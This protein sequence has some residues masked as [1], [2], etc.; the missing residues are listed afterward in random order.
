MVPPRYLEPSCSIFLSAGPGAGKTALLRRWHAASPA[1]A[2]YTGLTSDDLSV[3]FFL[4]RLLLPWP[5][6]RAPFEQLRQDLPDTE[7]GALL[8]LALTAAA[9]DFRLLLDDFHLCE[10]TPLEPL[11]LGLI[12]QFPPAGTLV[13]ASRHRPPRLE[14]PGLEVWDA[15]HPAWQGKASRE[16]WQALPSALQEQVVAL[17]VVGEFADLPDGDELVRRNLAK[18]DGSNLLLLLPHWREAAEQAL[19][20][21]VPSTVWHLVADG[22]K[23]HGRRHF[24]TQEGRAGQQRLGKVPP[25]ARQKHAYFLRL[26]GSMLLEAGNLEG[27]WATFDMALQACEAEPQELLDTLLEMATGASIQRDLERFETLMAEL[28]PQQDRLTAA[29]RARFL[30]LR[31]WA[32]WLAADTAAVQALWE[33]VLSV[34]PLGDRAVSYEHYLALLGQHVTQNNQGMRLE[35]T[36]YAERLFALVTEQNFDRVLLDAHNARLRCHMLDPQGTCS[37]QTVLE[38]PL[39]AF[40]APSPD[41]VLNFVSLLASRALKAQAY[42]TADGY[43]RHMKTLAIR[44]GTSAFVQMS[45]LHLLEIACFQ[46]RTVE[47]RVLFDELMRHP[48][49]N[50]QLNLVRLT[51]SWAL[52]KHGDAEAAIRLLREEVDN[53]PLDD[54]REHA[55]SLLR[56]I[57]GEPIPAPPVLSRQSLR[58]TF[59][60]EAMKGNSW[61]SKV[62]CRAF[63]DLTMTRDGT[64][65]LQLSRHKALTLLG[66]LT[67]NPDGLPSETLAEHLFGDPT[68]LNLLHSAAHSLRQGFKKL[69]TENLLESAGGMYR[70]RWCEV[71]LCDLHE[72]DALYRKARALENEGLT[73]GAR[74]FFELALCV[75]SA[76]LLDNLPDDFDSARAAHA[77]KLR[78]ARAF[79]A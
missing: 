69:G 47:A 45:N 29:Q 59:W 27:G 39:R 54:L 50:D 36:R 48:L 16:D 73:Q 4:H 64:S 26:E 25:E 14:R 20:R 24:Q 3:E 8:G 42:S 65:Q 76:P 12:R 35:A 68:D 57:E 19:G 40:A 37:I 72:F 13:V 61:P 74:L 33:Q 38:V 67:L 70:L 28:A 43:F 6:I 51:W 30:N 52:A 71:A 23:A 18:R 1:P 56:A 17:H 22:L 34:P 15:E 41:A 49:D 2:S 21:G 7:P 77:G 75:A 55:Q 79:C 10:G 32:Q 31:A 11:L 46:G 78:H 58:K 9:P 63:G 5:E 60:Q 44:Y 62:V 66:Y 53:Q